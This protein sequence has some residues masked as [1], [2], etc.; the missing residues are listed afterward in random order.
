[1]GERR[2]LQYSGRTDRTGRAALGD[3]PAVRMTG[4]RM[5]G[6]QLPC[7]DDQLPGPARVTSKLWAR[8][9]LVVPFFRVGSDSDINGGPVADS[10]RPRRRLG[11]G[12]GAARTTMARRRAGRRLS[13]SPSLPPSLSLSLICIYIQTALMGL[14]PLVPLVA[15]VAAVAVLV[16]AVTLPSSS[17]SSSSSSAAAA[18]GSAEGGGG[19]AGY[20]PLPDGRPALP[21]TRAW[22]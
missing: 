5:S 8:G 9:E 20:S 10:D 21:A 4:C 3:R 13:L 22:M 12:P 19:G 18:A 16:A 11:S 15:A 6:D 7:L 2:G 14:G 17:S 1:V